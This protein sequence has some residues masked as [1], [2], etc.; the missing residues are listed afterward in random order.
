MDRLATLFHRAADPRPDGELLAAF[1][2]ERDGDAFAELVRR[3][4][5]TIWGVCRR[6]LPDLA[7][8]EDAF[9]AT[10]LVL[11]R[12]A[13]RLVATPTVGPWLFEVA[14]RTAA[15]A[16]RKNS[17]RRALFEGLPDAVADPR[18]ATAPATDLDTI[19]HGLPERYRAVL[20]MCYLEG[21]THREAAGRL[22]CAEGTVSSLVSRGLAKLR[23]KFAGREPAA[24][25]AVAG[26]AV[27]VG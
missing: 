22:G 23:T 7:D 4:G 6:A 24:V 8:A 3:H 16:R 26:V 27:P 15:N 9:Q 10:F 14:V 13:S 5:P 18:P 12:R 17:R 11:V 20:L 19:L 21:L 2:D 1:L 25:L